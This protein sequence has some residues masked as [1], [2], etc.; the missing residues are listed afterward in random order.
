MFFINLTVSGV[1]VVENAI[2]KR[3]GAPF[4]KWQLK[5]LRALWPWGA[6]TPSSPLADIR[7]IATWSFVPDKQDMGGYYGGMP[8]RLVAYPV[9]NNVWHHAGDCDGF[10]VHYETFHQRTHDRHGPVW[11]PIGHS[12]RLLTASETCDLL[13]SC[14]TLTGDGPPENVNN[15]GRLKHALGNGYEKTGFDALDKDLFCELI[16]SLF[17]QDLTPACQIVMADTPAKLE[18][19]PAAYFVRNFTL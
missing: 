4:M 3:Q 15:P 7:R 11:Q 5:S 9:K 16:N 8:A 14:E 18:T 13:T 6:K 10:Q 17:Q 1:S 12:L 2:K 19:V